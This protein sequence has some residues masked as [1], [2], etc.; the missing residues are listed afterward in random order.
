MSDP[1]LYPHYDSLAER[2][3]VWTVYGPFD[4]QRP[5]ERL[6]KAEIDFDR[7]FPVIRLSHAPTDPVAYFVA[8]HEL[9][10]LAIDELQDGT[11]FVRRAR[12]GKLD[13]EAR[14]WLWALNTALIEPTIEVWD[15]IIASVDSYIEWAE[16]DRRVKPSE[17]LEAL[18]MHAVRARADLAS[19]EAPQTGYPVSRPYGPDTAVVGTI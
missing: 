13:H 12:C 16:G 10:H 17:E 3:G 1:G 4:G 18:L 8:L 2:Y 15:D 7:G 14:A 19:R 6:G 9:G 11:G 5:E